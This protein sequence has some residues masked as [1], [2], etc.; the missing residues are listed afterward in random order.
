MTNFYKVFL[1]VFILVCCNISH[2]AV[3]FIG[4]TENDVGPSQGSY[5]STHAMDNLPFVYNTGYNIGYQN[6][7]VWRISG[8]FCVGLDGK[9]DLPVVGSLDGQSIYGL[10]EEV[11]LL[12]WMGD[13]NYSRGT[14]MS[15]NS[16]ENV[17]SGWCVGN[18]VSTQGL[19]VHVR[20]VIL[21]R[22]SSAQYSVQKTSIGSIRM[23]PY[24]G[25]SAGSVQTTVNFSLNPFTLNDT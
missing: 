25:S 20:P 18:Y 23:R 2:A 24:N 10:T 19:S 14:A 12:I 8:G 21:K 11:G 7:N 3:S 16:W 5:S 17:F 6:A 15:G 1:A 4:S 13:T 9:V 22:N